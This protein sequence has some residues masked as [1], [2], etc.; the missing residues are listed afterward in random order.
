MNTRLLIILG[1]TASGKSDLAVRLAKKY[2]GEVVSADSRQVYKG[3]N[4][5]T[6]KITKNEMKGIRHHLLDVADP[7]KQFTVIDYRKLAD[8]AIADITK[9]GKL[10]IICGGT[11]FY[12]DT[13]VNERDFPAAKADKK[14]R[15][16]LSKK[17]VE[18]L[19]AMLTKLDPRRAKTMAANNSERH[20]SRRLIRAIEI[21]TVQMRQT[22]IEGRHSADT[23]SQIGI[24]IHAVALEPALYRKYDS[25]FIGIKVPRNEL[26][27]RIKKRLRARMK[28]GMLAEAKRLHEPRTKRNPNGGLS[29]KR[30]NELGLEYRYEAELLQGRLNREQFMETLATKIWQYA[31]RQ[32]TWFRRN[33]KIKWF[34][35]NQYLKIE[36][37]IRRKSSP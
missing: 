36:K 24:P 1:P 31:R 16:K 11:G 19:L 8:K 18:Q 15:A 17:S 29:W 10:P 25:L 21:T 20:N 28:A 26:R 6:G 35:R 7:K 34:T 14:L 37:L 5:G 4:I 13:V 2:N 22:K 33:R 27:D 3:L 30:M 9:R 12:I 23:K 32:M